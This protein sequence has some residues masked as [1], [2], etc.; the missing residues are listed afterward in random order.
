MST[1]TWVR[2]CT[3]AVRL[4]VL[5]ILL[6]LPMAQPSGHPASRSGQVRLLHFLKLRY[7]GTCWYV[8]GYGTVVR[9]IRLYD[10]AR[11]RA[12]HH[13]YVAV[14]AALLAAGMGHARPSERR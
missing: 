3:P 2:T 9:R 5:L 12:G 14:R 8:P 6:S 1:S 4:Y 13:Q 10:R 7:L 11:A